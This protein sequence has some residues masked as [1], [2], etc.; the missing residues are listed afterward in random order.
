M[1]I[2]RAPLAAAGAV[3]LGLVPAP[4]VQAQPLRGSENVARASFNLLRTYFNSLRNPAG[5]APAAGPRDFNLERGSGE[6]VTREVAPIAR[7]A[8][9]LRGCRKASFNASWGFKDAPGRV[10]AR[11]DWEC[12]AER[13]EDRSVRVTA[14]SRDGRTVDSV[15]ARLGE[16]ISWP[17]P[18]PSMSPQPSAAESAEFESNKALAFAFFDRLAAGEPGA[19]PTEFV[20]WSGDAREVSTLA[21]AREILASCQRLE[22]HRQST[23]VDG[24]TRTGVHLL[25]KCDR[26]SGA[27]ADLSGF[28]TFSDGVMDRFYLSP[29]LDYQIPPSRGQQD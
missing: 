27:Y 11:Q 19:A 2:G 26:E 29:Y 7:L 14:S 9:M 23:S 10:D 8:A 4:G 24:A 5:E 16:R 15:T 20:I 22:T 1:N 25:W 28:L 6:T 3:L 13:V 18:S 17:G 21:R 12:R